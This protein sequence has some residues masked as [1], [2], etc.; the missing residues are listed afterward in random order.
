PRALSALVD[1]LSVSHIAFLAPT[2]NIAM[3]DEYEPGEYDLSSLR[4]VCYGGAPIY[5]EQLRQ[6]IQ[7]FGPVFTQIYGQGEAPITIT[8][9]SAAAHA[10]LL[11]AGDERIGSA[12]ITRTDVEARVV[13]P[14]DRPLPPGE[15]GE[16]VAR[17]EVVMLGYWH[18]PEATAETLRGGW[19]HTGD[20]GRFDEKGYLF[21]LDRAKD[22]IISGGNNIY[23]REVEEVIVQHPAVA[24]C[25][26]LGIPH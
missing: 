12:G 9:L 15:G 14:D 11:E 16:V 20:I 18:N 3:L 7:A 2:Q 8:G 5:V 23:P 13:G 21:L 4:A 22:V 6:A 17:C 1:R 24:N 19:L 10:E 26:V 25:V